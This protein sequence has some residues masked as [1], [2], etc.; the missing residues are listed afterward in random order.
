MKLTDN[1]ARILYHGDSSSDPI[2][3]SQIETLVKDIIAV[4]QLS[5]TY[6]DLEFNSEQELHLI[7]GIM[8]LG[9]ITE[10]QRDVLYRLLDRVRKAWTESDIKWRLGL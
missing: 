5:E 4:G 3:N 10:E 7:D 9:W 2:T 1:D 8:Y 6:D